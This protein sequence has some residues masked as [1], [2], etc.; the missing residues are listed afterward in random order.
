VPKIDVDAPPDSGVFLV[1]ALKA[2]AAQH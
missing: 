1:Q 2:G